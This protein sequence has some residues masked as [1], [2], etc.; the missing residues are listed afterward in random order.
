MTCQKEKPNAAESLVKRSAGSSLSYGNASM[1][2]LRL[3]PFIF[4]VLFLKQ[5]FAAAPPVVIEGPIW[6]DQFPSRN[7]I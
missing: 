2:L 6:A 5:G 4:T 1:K 7:A 3:L